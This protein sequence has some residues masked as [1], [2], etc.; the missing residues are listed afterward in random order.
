MFPGL[1]DHAGVEDFGVGAAVAFEFAG[2]G[3]DQGV[4]HGADSAFVQVAW[5]GDGFEEEA[6]VVVEAALLA[7]GFGDVG[8]VGV[9]GGFPFAFPLHGNQAFFEEAED[10]HGEDAFE[11]DFVEDGGF[12]DGEAA[13]DA[14]GFDFDGRREVAAFDEAASGA[15]ECRILDDADAAGA[16]DDDEDDGVEEEFAVGFEEG[17]EVEAVGGSVGGV[18]GGDVGFVIGEANAMDEALGVGGT[19]IFPGVDQ[20]GV[21]P[22]VA[23]GGSVMVFG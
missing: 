3:F 17:P 16:E 8:A 22:V 9:E 5:G 18:V 23:G 11:G 13:A 1:V 6:F 19:E 7:G 2:R 12:D 4:E 14:E 20:T 15:G 10:D 21:G